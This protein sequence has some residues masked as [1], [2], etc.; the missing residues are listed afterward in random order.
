MARTIAHLGTDDFFAVEPAA[1][2]WLREM[3]IA[4]VGDPSLRRAVCSPPQR[5]AGC[6]C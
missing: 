2:V 3:P 5:K 1:D 4:V 6:G